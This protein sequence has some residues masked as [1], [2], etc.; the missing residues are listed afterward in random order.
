M[1]AGTT[2]AKANVIVLALDAS[3]SISTGDFALQR[4]GYV[5]ALT[6]LLQ[7]NGLNAIAVVQFSDAVTSVFSMR[8]INT[9]QDKTD[10]INALSTF[11]R[12]SGNTAI[13][14]AVNN[15]RL[16]IL[17]QTGLCLTT[18]H[19]IVDVSTDGENNTGDNLATAV[20]NA[21]NAGIAVNCLGVGGGASCGWNGTGQDWFATDFTAFATAINAKLS[22]EL[23]PTPEPMTLTLFGAGL[24]GAGFMRR[25][26]K[27]A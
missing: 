18:V 15:G 6:N 13:G 24:I 26:M 8:V 9:A 4:Q 3:T 1:F 10:L 7:P 2:S 25:R 19:C 11:S 5:T 22:A 21:Q 12:I 14:S 17:A 23:T 20:T 27:K 16:S